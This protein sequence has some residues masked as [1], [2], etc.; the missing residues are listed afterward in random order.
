MCFLDLKEGL[1][2]LQSI[3]ATAGEQSSQDRPRGNK[4]LTAGGVQKVHLN[5]FKCS[6]DFK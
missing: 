3:I 5:F 4:A 1:Q 6:L 2:L